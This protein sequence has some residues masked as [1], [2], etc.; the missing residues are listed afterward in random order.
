MNSRIR[1][2]LSSIALV[3]SIAA[4]TAC[5]E[6]TQD[7]SDY[8][9]AHWSFGGPVGSEIADATGKYN[10]TA[11]GVSASD[12]AAWHFPGDEAHARVTHEP[13]LDLVDGY[14]MEATVRLASLGNPRNGDGIQAILEK[15]LGA[16]GWLLVCDSEGRLL[17]WMETPD[18]HRALDTSTVALEPGQWYHVALTWDGAK[19]VFY[20]DGK[21]AGEAEFAGPLGRCDQDI[22]LGNDDTLN[23]SWNGD[24]ADI[25]ISN[26]ALTPDE[27]HTVR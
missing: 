25:R 11:T 5:T 18:G 16:G 14:T 12:E 27:F 10:G 26:K 21:P 17:Y 9:V 1:H 2:T 13:T 15:H 6:G 20:V 8:V 4:L 7:M 22:Y 19:T 23:W 3:A 24:I